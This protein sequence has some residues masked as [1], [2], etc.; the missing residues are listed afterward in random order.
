MPAST[1]R[2]MA[3]KTVELWF[4]G[5]EEGQSHCKYKIMSQVVG[6]VNDFHGIQQRPTAKLCWNPE[7]ALGQHSLKLKLTQNV[8]ADKEIVISYGTRQ[9]FGKRKAT[10]GNA[11]AKKKN[12]L[13]A[14]PSGAGAAAGAAASASTDSGNKL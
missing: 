11:N 9:F 4:Q 7:R 2:S 10:F 3:L 12:K 1:A 5:S 6:F 14:L 13:T 8:E